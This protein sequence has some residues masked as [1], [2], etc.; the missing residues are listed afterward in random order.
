MQPDVDSAAAVSNLQR[1]PMQPDVEPASVV[2]DLQRHTDAQAP[3]AEE[4][5]VEEMDQNDT[6]GMESIEKK[7]FSIHENIQMN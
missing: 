2:A 3:E 4:S 1:P 6:L 7:K 5:R